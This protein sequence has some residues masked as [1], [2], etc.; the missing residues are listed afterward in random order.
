M[1]F[2][3][4][5]T[6]CTYHPLGSHCHGQ[7][8]STLSKPD[9]LASSIMHIDHHAHRPS[10]INN[11]SPPSVVPWNLY[12]HL[13]LSLSLSLYLHLSL[14]C[15]PG[16]TRMECLMRISKQ[17]KYLYP[18]WQPLHPTSAHARAATFST[19]QLQYQSASAVGNREYRFQLNEYRNVIAAVWAW[20]SACVLYPV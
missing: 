6:Y 7:I 17:K 18:T 3:T 19:R 20:R 11:C 4:L 12:F 8:P 10:S 16:L 1:H 2:C 9:L 14:P 5:P 15:L 13:Y